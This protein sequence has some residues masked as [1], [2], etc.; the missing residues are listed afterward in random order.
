MKEMSMR[1]S[2]LDSLRGIAALMVAVMHLWEFLK[3]R[4]V[5]E[6]TTII[7]KIINLVILDCLNFGKLGIVIFF[8]ISGYV[9]PFSLK[10]KNVKKFIVTRFF[11]L[12]PAYWFS[13]LLYVIVGG[14]I[15]SIYVLVANI[16][17]FHKFA[18]I[19]D[20]VGVYWTLQIELSF[21]ILCCFLFYKK[22]LFR[23]RTISTMIYGILIM[24]LIMSYFRYVMEIKFPV[25]LLLG[26]VLMFLGMQWRI[27]SESS[28]Y[29]FI[30]RNVCFFILT[31]IPVC[32]LAYNKDFGYNEKWYKYFV[33]YL[34]GL[35]MFRLFSKF[36]IKSNALNFL[37]NISYSVY[38]LHPA[39]LVLLTTITSIYTLS[40][41][42]YISFFFISMF[43]FS[44][45][46]YYIIE[47]P[48]IK[49][50]RKFN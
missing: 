13:L 50:G 44:L 33:S 28:N 34:L 4:Y 10:N 23:E 37:G 47:K 18:G 1:I 29:K 32:F 38:L 39:S 26:L 2:W 15:H 35:V 42:Q 20:L 24:A 14:T 45:S 21:Y 48:M 22:I 41:Y 27:A 46:S 7:S 40:F 9:I 30:K 36:R 5:A 16:T 17:M 25:T 6:T 49:T 3:V 43:L 12:Y 31:L 19:P 8:M 11:R